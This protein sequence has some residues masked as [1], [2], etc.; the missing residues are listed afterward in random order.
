MDARELFEKVIFNK[1]SVKNKSDVNSINDHKTWMKKNKEA[2]GIIVLSLTTEQTI[3]YKE[4]KKG[5][6]DIKSMI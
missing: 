6:T 4:M 2:L 5:K 3:I 1:E